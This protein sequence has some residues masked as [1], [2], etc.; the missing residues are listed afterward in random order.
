M[1]LP[2]RDCRHDEQCETNNST[3]ERERTDRPGKTRSSIP[4]RETITCANSSQQAD[5]LELANVKKDS[6]NKNRPPR[7]VLLGKCRRGVAP[8]GNGG[9][10]KFFGEEGER[11]AKRLRLR[12]HPADTSANPLALLSW[13]SKR[14]DEVWTRS[15]WTAL[16]V[17]LHN[18]NG[19]THSGQAR[20]VGR[21]REDRRLRCE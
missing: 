4:D 17:H 7:F 13:Q 20:Q 9:G 16:C 6:L 5:A 19:A 21:D 8:V 1:N 2:A 18:G 12:A 15:E 14:A 10:V 11:P 3:G